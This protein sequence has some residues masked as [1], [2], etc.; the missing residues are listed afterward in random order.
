MEL[1]VLPDVTAVAKAAAQTVA[2]RARSAV[3]SKGTFLLA[4]SGGSTPWKMIEAIS[5]ESVPWDK[6][7]IFQVDERVAPEGHQDRNLTQM[8]A[9]LGSHSAIPA[10]NIHPMPVNNPNLFEAST[11]YATE[12]ADLV[13]DNKGIDLIHLGL[14]PD[15][16]I[17]SLVPN[18][19]VLDEHDR[20]VAIT[21]NTYQ[22]R[23]RMTLTYPTINAANEILWLV[24]GASKLEMLGRLL[25]GDES[26]P[27]GRIST[28]SSLIFAD[29]EAVPDLAINKS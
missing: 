10:A 7:H 27:A 9:S 15:G 18:D 22:G 16:H 23:L 26:I 21:G 19:S 6:V 29:E 25:E 1:R 28:A 17:A 12:I 14:G 2:S 3:Q 4:L 5:K 11:N 13:G 8:I 20:A 24:T